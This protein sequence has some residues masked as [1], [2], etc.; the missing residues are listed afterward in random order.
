MGASGDNHL[1]QDPE[2]SLAR[3]AIATL[4]QKRIDY[5]FARISGD[6]DQ[7]VE[8]FRRWYEEERPNK[9]FEQLSVNDD[10]AK[11]VAV[12]SSMVSKSITRSLSG[13]ALR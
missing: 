4:A 7:M 11:F 8:L 5:Y 2:G 13:N 6:T 9:H 3:K 12:V 10:P 1:H